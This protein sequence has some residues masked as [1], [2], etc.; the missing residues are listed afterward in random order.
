[1]KC[2]KNLETKEVTRTYDERANDLV[3]NGKFSFA[4]KKEWKEQ[5]RKK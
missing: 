2:I 1:M 4:S 5:G 3:K